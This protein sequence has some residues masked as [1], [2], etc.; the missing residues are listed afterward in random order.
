[1]TWMAVADGTIAFAYFAIPLEFLFF[2]L[3]YSPRVG[4][5]HRWKRLRPVLLVITFF[6]LCGMTHLM[7]IIALWT[8][9]PAIFEAHLGIKVVTGFVSTAGAVALLWLIPVA[10]ELPVRA[11]QLEAEVN[12]RIKT[13][14]RLQRE[15]DILAKLRNMAQAI[16]RSLDKPTILRTTTVELV[17]V[18]Q[19]DV[20]A[21]LSP[22]AAAKPSPSASPPLVAGPIITLQAPGPGGRATATRWVYGPETRA[23]T[24]APAVYAVVASGGVAPPAAAVV[25]TTQHAELP[26]WHGSDDDGG[27]GDDD[28]YSNSSHDGSDD[29]APLLRAAAVAAGSIQAGGQPRLQRS[30]RGSAALLQW[31]WR[32]DQAVILPTTVDTDLLFNGAPPSSPSTLRIACRVR[33]P[34]GVSPRSILEHV[35]GAE[36]AGGSSPPDAAAGSGTATAEVCYALLLVEAPPA[37]LEAHGEVLLLRLVSDIAAQVEIALEQ[38]HQIDVERIRM[39]QLAEQNLALNQAR[40][41]VQA[42]TYR[43]HFFSMMSHEIRTPM[44]A[45]VALTDLLLASSLTP[46]Q[47]YMVDTL[48]RSGDHLIAI[49][50]DILDYAKVEEGQL[51]LEWRPLSLRK[52]VEEVIEL[53]M[54]NQRLHG[55]TVTAGTNL[56]YFY[57]PDVPEIVVGD[58]TRIAQLLHNLLSNA[59]KFT[60][61]GDIL[62]SIRVA[63]EPPPAAAAGSGSTQAAAGQVPARRAL[64]PNE[65][66]LEVT[67]SDTGCGIPN[68]RIPFLFDRF[69]QADLS[70]TRRHGGTG[71]GL[72]ITHALVQLMG[73][74][75]HVDSQVGQGTTFTLDFAV[76]TLP[77]AQLSRR[78]AE[79]AATEAAGVAA[80]PADTAFLRYWRPDPA[81]HLPPTLPRAAAAAL[82]PSLPAAAFD[83]VYV[84][85]R[86]PTN[87]AAL[88]ALLTN[89]GVRPVIKAGSL[90]EAT[91]LVVPSDTP[92]PGTYS[93]RALLLDGP[94]LRAGMDDAKALAALLGLPTSSSPDD[95]V[96]AAVQALAGVLPVAVIERRFAA[97]YPLLLPGVGHAERPLP[98]ITGPAELQGPALERAGRVRGVLYRPASLAAVRALLAKLAHTTLTTPAVAAAPPPGTPGSSATLTA[99]EAVRILVVDDNDI[100]VMVTRRLLGRLGYE[101]ESVRSGPEALELLR[102]RAHDPAAAVQLVFMDVSMP[103]M[104]GIEATR[105]L[106]A[107][108][109][110]DAPRPYVVALTANSSE[111]DRRRCTAAGMDDFLGKPVKLDGFRQAID[112]Y[113]AS[114][115]QHVSV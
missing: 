111:D 96:L 71:L 7:A 92:S 1:M 83:A 10:M 100:N 53:V 39:A 24:A 99:P 75:I 6:V 34:I 9:S 90:L 112:R 79:L 33:L 51:Q 74:S 82:V 98:A 95:V 16:R 87:A 17:E 62:L 55:H 50:N 46:D 45:V 63:R 56:N 11:L 103:I 73:G 19:L 78:L 3:H 12:S 108:W 22:V 14:T 113:L 36:V 30:G 21:F 28:D 70:T 110:A 57:D 86:A 4:P 29:A 32:T 89:D 80:D 106:R 58:V 2:G 115:G 93:R 69:M 88:A 109:P 61:Q 65:M 15:Y 44:Y 26:E 43:M 49:T 66:R 47:A 114:R 101:V 54:V 38:A 94:T 52:C 5:Q 68:D 60:E 97:A 40:K 104:D 8:L 84:V 72:A 67:V 31:I 64:G 77:P 27:S 18:L 107:T 23:L 48:R 102:A 25:A 76:E 59:A 35:E 105:L 91:R 13:E 85:D 41:E 20:C 37:A 42:A 81:L